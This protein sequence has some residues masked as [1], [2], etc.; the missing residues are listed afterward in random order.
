MISKLAMPHLLHSTLGY[1]S[2]ELKI[3]INEG[4]TGLDPIFDQNWYKDD[5]EKTVQKKLVQ[6]LH[7]T[8]QHITSTWFHYYN[9]T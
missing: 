7:V 9:E 3:L 4:L 6:D 1:L 8:I 5:M 2:E